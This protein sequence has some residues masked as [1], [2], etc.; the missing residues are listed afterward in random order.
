MKKI[1]F[2]C[3]IEK[4]VSQFYKHKGMADGHLNKCK[5]CAKSDV[6]SNYKLKS[7]DESF[8]EKERIRGREKY[9]RLNYKEKFFDYKKE[10]FWQNNSICKNLHRNLNC[11]AGYELHHWNY[12]DDYLK[13]VIIVSRKQ[14][15]KIHVNLIFDPLLLVFRTKDGLLLDTKEKHLNYILQHEKIV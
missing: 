8:I 11:P 13:D 15:K 3:N 12:N 4:D 7:E 6:Q 10:R 14:H 1:C 5:S 9:H 2:K